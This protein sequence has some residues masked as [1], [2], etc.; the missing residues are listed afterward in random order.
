MKLCFIYDRVNKIGGAEKVLQELHCLYP[1][2]P[3]Y[4]AVYDPHATPWAKDIRVIPSWVNRIPGAKSHHEQLPNLMPYA[5]ESF[6]LS[7]YDIIISITSAEAKGVITGPH[8]LH[9]CYLLTPTRYLWSH[10]NI[11]QGKGIMGWIRSI[12]LNLLTTWDKVACT[13]PDTYISISKAV[14]ARCQTYYHRQSDA[15]IYP[16]VNTAQFANHPEPCA[17]PGENYWLVVSR[18]VP[19]KQVDMAIKAC[20]QL[21]EP[22]IIVGNGS[23]LH[24]LKQLAGPTITFMGQVDDNTLN[25]LYHHAKALIFPQE[26][27]FGITA[28]EAQA[29]GVPVV[30]FKGGAAPEIIRDRETGI[31]FPYQTVASL[32]EGMQFL[33]THT[34]YDKTIKEHAAQFEAA[35]FREQFKQF[36]EASWQQFHQK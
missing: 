18:L 11:H 23:E 5:F 31:L 32:I 6:D 34:W 26:E 13:R 30:A 8:Q 25:C 3:L 36:V 29:A 33:K 1:D 2:A 35:R 21:K 19:Y 17:H 12:G 24:R 16:P 14:D 9:L 28:I 7:A 4:T 22:L 15:I 10:R 27:E 20:N